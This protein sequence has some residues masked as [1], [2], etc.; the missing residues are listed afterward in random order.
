MRLPW[1]ARSS[2]PRAEDPDHHQTG[3]GPDRTGRLFATGTTNNK[4]I[5]EDRFPA[6]IILDEE[7]LPQLAQEVR[8]EL[9]SVLAI[10]GIWDA[11]RSGRTDHR[12]APRLRYPS[13]FFKFVFDVSHQGYASISAT[14]CC[15]R[16]STICQYEGPPAS[17]A[18]RAITTATAR[19]TPALLSPPLG[20]AAARDMMG[21]DEHVVCVAGDAAYP[22]RVEALTTSPLLHEETHRRLND[23][24]GR[25]EE[26][27]RRRRVP[28]LNVANPAYAQS[29]ESGAVRLMARRQDRIK[30]RWQVRG[31]HEELH[32][33]ERHLRRPRPPL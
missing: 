6:D 27:R 20:M 21:G 7:Q 24:D 22:R 28:Q 16:F 8:N 18:P 14:G 2:P 10:G 23:N 15:E 9:T 3:E 32:R 25:R 17:S 33:P 11:T 4:T 29:H 30:A 19:A 5:L 12:P 1:L 26:R 13:V 31:G